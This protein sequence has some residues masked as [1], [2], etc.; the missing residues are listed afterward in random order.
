L[1]ADKPLLR[2]LLLAALGA[3]FLWWAAPGLWAYFAADDP[4]NLYVG[5]NATWLKYAWDNVLFFTGPARPLGNLFFKLGFALFGLDP[6]PYRIACFA[7]LLV[8]VWLTYAVA[9]Q[10]SRSRV[11][12]FLTSLIAAYHAPLAGLYYLTAMVYDVLAY[13]FFFAAF[14]LAARR[15]S[16]WATCVLFVCALNSKEIAVVLPAVLAAYEWFCERERRWRWVAATAVIAAAWTAGKLLAADSMMANPAYHPALD[17][18]VWLE[19]LRHYMRLMTVLE[20]DWPGWAVGALGAALAAAAWV[21]RQG[22][23]RWAAA[24]IFLATLPVLPIE[25]RSYYALYIAYFGWALFLGALLTRLPKPWLVT[26]IAAALLVPLHIWATPRMTGDITASQNYV[27]PVMEQ[28][29]A[30]KVQLARP[31]KVLFLED[32]FP[33]DE[34]ML[35]LILALIHEDPA[36]EVMRPKRMDHAPSADEIASCQAVFRFKD[37]RLTR[38]R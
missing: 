18:R 20:W 17:P 32:P 8:N 4:M 33:E 21:S 15:K 30:Q 23:V 28:L 1:G 5:W 3:W 24:L 37:G 38:V 2:A 6:L 34:W 10:V 31:G 13:L 14:L 25:P 26:S 7:L 27:R 22:A 12:A 29:K 19:H 11:T 35:T 9:E 16:L 36:M